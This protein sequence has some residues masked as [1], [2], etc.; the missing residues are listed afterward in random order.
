VQPQ[1]LAS[2]QVIELGDVLVA[3]TPP[4]GHEPPTFRLSLRIIPFALPGAN[5]NT[6]ALSSSFLDPQFRTFAFTFSRFLVFALVDLYS[7]KI[8]QG[9]DSQDRAARTG[10]PEQDSQKAGHAEQAEQD[11]QNKTGR[12]AQEELDRENRT[13][14]AGLPGKDCQI[15]LTG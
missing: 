15:G 7:I 13:G 4:G 9:E 8:Q 10:Q 6:P 5:P 1:V 2:Q 11:W 3:L 14:R 12:A